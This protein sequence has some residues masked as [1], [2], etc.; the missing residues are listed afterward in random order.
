MIF[1][2]KEDFALSLVVAKLPSEESFG[3][4]VSPY[5]WRKET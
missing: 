5:G 2:N 4:N 1:G 3:T